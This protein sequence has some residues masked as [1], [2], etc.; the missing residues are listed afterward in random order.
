MPSASKSTGKNRASWDRK[1]YRYF[2][3][4]NGWFWRDQFCTE[5]ARHGQ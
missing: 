4:K 2:K 1:A 5:V 3:R